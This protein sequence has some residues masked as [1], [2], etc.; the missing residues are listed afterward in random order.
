MKLSLSNSLA[1]LKPLSVPFVGVLDGFTPTYAWSHRRALLSSFTGNIMQA[2]RTSDSS[3]YNVSRLSTGEGN[4]AG[5]QT[6]VGSNTAAVA[7]LTEQAGTGYDL[8]QATGDNQRILIDAGTLVTVGGKAASRGRR[9]D[10]PDHDDHQPGGTLVASVPAYTGTTMSVFLRMENGT[11][12]GWFGGL[13]AAILNVGK[14]G[15]G[16][17]GSTLGAFFMRHD[18][19]GN[20]YTVAANFSTLLNAAIDPNGLFSIIFDGTNVT[21]RDGTN[22]YTTAYTTAFDINRI[23]VGGIHPDDGGAYSS[24]GFRF[25]ELAI[26]NS[27]QTSNESAIRSAMLA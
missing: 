14:N 12:S 5:L 25:Q 9:L 6:F 1:A 4:I 19:G 20:N 24:R 10:Y 8:T 15:T 7:S 11:H 16:N 21:F 2:R 23:T 18:P 22:T 13:V 17:G 27:N 26:F 3:P